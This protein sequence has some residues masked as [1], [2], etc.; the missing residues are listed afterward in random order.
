M[1]QLIR[2]GIL[3]SL[4][5]AANLSQAACSFDIEVGDYLKFST[6]DMT[7]QK[8]CNSI[9]VN[10][11][12]T[13]KMPAKIMGHNWVLAESAVVQAIATE[14]MSAGLTEN[15]VPKGDDRVL[16]F[17]KVI[18]GG[19]TASVT[20]STSNLVAGEAYTFFCSFPGHSYGM[21]G[22]FKVNI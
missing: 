5:G 18:G 10:L 8:S 9:T 13:G 15:Y 20:F 3:I 11:K 6:A 19:E 16:A 12:H 7:I 14:G 22:A 21:R 1:K 17:S 2:L 4:S